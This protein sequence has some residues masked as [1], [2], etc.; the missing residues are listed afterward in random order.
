MIQMTL[1]VLHSLSLLLLRE[2]DSDRYGWTSLRSYGRHS[3][4]SIQTSQR[5]Q[6]VSKLVILI[7]KT[8]KMTVKTL[9]RKAF[10]ID[11]DEYTWIE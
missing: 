10:M 3:L 8:Q 6:I 7:T 1:I 11:E 9:Q 5:I 4:F 2:S